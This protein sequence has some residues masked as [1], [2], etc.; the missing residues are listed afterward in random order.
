MF[1]FFLATAPLQRAVRLVYFFVI[2]II[3]GFVI[4]R[5]ME[6][7]CTKRT[8]EEMLCGLPKPC[9]CG[10]KRHRNTFA[11][12][13]S[14]FRHESAIENSESLI[15]AV[16]KISLKFPSRYQPL[17]KRNIT[18]SIHYRNHA[19]RAMQLWIFKI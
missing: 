1:C 4:I 10:T 12:T 17:N 14:F 2:L 5:E 7:G 11:Q 3:V 18:A 19:T 15:D 6:C 9:R 8:N 13:G 16:Q